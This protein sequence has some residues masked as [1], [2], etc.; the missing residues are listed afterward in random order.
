MTGILS[1]INS[2]QDIK[3]L[4]LAQKRLLA[5]ET[6]EYIIDTVAKN[7]GHLAP[8]LGVVELTI[9]LHSVFNSP[10]D[11]I[12]WDVGHQCYAHKIF[13]GR[14]EEFSTLRTLGGL[15]G[16]PKQSE[17]PHDTANTGHAST[18]ISQAVGY[19]IARDLSGEDYSVIAVIGDG[20]MTGGMVYEAF[21]HAGVR[22]SPLIVVLNDNEKSIDDNVGAMADYLLKA[23]TGARYG[24]LKDSVQRLLQSSPRASRRVKRFKD[25]I[26]YLL[27][28]GMFFEELGFTYLGPIDGHNIAEIITALERAK[29][30]EEPVLLHL[31]T[32]KGKGYAPAEANPDIFH[33]L[34]PFDKANGNIAPKALSYTKV[35]GNY[36][37]EQ[38]KKNNKIVAITAAMTSGTGLMQFFNELPNQSIDVG[39]AEQ[40]AVT[41]ASAM[42]SGGLRPVVAVYS[43][44]FQRAYDQ[45]LHDVCL[46]NLPVVLALDRAG[47]VGE[48]GSTHQGV[49]D[50]SYLRSMPNLLIMAPK[51]GNELQSMLKTALN[52]SSPVAVRYPRASVINFDETAEVLP[53]EIGKAEVLREGHSLSIWA[54]GS[55]VEPALTAAE[56]LAA[57]GI[58]AQVIN[59]RFVAP[60]DCSLLIKSAQDCGRLVTVE[61]NVAT[62]GFG[63][64]VLEVLSKNNITAETLLLALP[65]IP[66]EQGKRVELLQQFGLSEEGIAQSIINRWFKEENL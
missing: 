46:P 29:V 43:T 27:V 40:H 21:N 3:P 58:E 12:I 32:K 8:N 52:C 56:L 11:K 23:R 13:T 18:S 44:F 1:Q 14:R 31:M 34:G 30:Y 53:L 64:A 6:R 36:L 25:S 42:A 37:L 54:I 19:T 20:A 47:I 57:Q 28:S 26:K 63:S 33:G 24:K 35:F 5:A 45:I 62:G 7:G 9:A 51:N 61:E 4:S 38:A 59:A 48:D 17:S 22:K 2:P 15:S 10:A 66:I 50:L 41:M 39:I 55:M 60:L 49:F 65:D 16:F